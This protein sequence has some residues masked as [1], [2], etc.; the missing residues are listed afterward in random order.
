MGCTACVTSPMYQT[1]LAVECSVAGHHARGFKS[2][3]WQ[4][5]LQFYLDPKGTGDK[6]SH[7]GHTH[8][9]RLFFMKWLCPF[10]LLRSLA[11]SG[12]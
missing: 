12:Q 8:S 10:T 4:T 1:N 11:T 6:Y 5:L 3:Q 9:I 7:C 2:P